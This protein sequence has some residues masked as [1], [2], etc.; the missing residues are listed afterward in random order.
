MVNFNTQTV[1]EI[2]GITRRQVQYWDETDFVKP[3]VR[4]A[5]GHGSTRLYSFFDLVQM[6][7]AKTLMKGGV[8][9]QKIRKTLKYLRIHAPK[10]KNPLGG[11]KFLTDGD[12]IFV[13]TAD[14]NIVEDTLRDGQLVFALALGNIVKDL[15]HNVQRFIVKKD[16]V[17]EAGG[18]QF[19]IT[20]EADPEKGGFRAK[21]PSLNPLSFFSGETEEEVL[22]LI[23]VVLAKEVGGCPKQ[24]AV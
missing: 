22:E 20:L 14:K 7:V 16:V 24:E 3:S 12:G 21:C 8:S 9:L 19:C 10:V 13:L 1:C 5:S 23:R 18:E 17:L 2:I 15:S 4:Q 11:L 6:R